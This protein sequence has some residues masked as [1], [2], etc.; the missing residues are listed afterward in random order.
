MISWRL[1]WALGQVL[2]TSSFPKHGETLR[3]PAQFWRALA[4]KIV[5]RLWSSPIR[6]RLKNGGEFSVAEFMTLYIYKEIFIDGC[7]D[8]PKLP[9]AAPCIID[10][11]ANTGLFAIRMKQLYPNATLHCYEPMP[12]NFK[13][14]QRNLALSQLEKCKSYAEGVGG[15]ARQEKL[16]IHQK[17]LGGHSIYAG[18]ASDESIDIKLVDLGTVLQRLDSGR[19]D[20]LKLDCEG[21][22]FEIIQSMDFDTA[23]KIDRIVFEPT[24]S[25]YHIDELIKPLSHLGYAVRWNEGLCIATRTS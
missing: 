14:L 13:S 10:I 24:S 15:N 8:E 17:N 19:C 1:N 23:E 20:L 25:K 3:S 21:A 12:A 16:Y 4:L 6:L 9:S 22:E 11:G 5:P 18:L 2:D 7:Y